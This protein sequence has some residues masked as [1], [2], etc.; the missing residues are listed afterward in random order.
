MTNEK[1]STSRGARF[2]ARV[3]KAIER[4]ERI[5]FV[6]DLRSQDY[7]KD[8]DGNSRKVDLSFVLCTWAVEILVSVECKSRNRPISLDQVDQIKVF[9][10]E[11]PERNI[12]WLVVEGDTGENVKVALESAGISL[13]VI[14]DLERIIDHMRRSFR[15][16]RIKRLRRSTHMFSMMDPGV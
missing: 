3:H 2:E 8:R 11:L 14:D 4:L 15:K 5:G 16:S 1:A 13:Y 10:T 9:K 7:V 6:R 12:F